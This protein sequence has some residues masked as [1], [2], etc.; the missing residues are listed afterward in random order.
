MSVPELSADLRGARCNNCGTAT[1]HAAPCSRCA[2]QPG[3][4]RP[5]P[6]LPAFFR[7]LGRPFAGMRFLSEHRR[8]WSY[9]LAPLLL[10]TA[11]FVGILMLTVS[12]LGDWIPDMDVAWHPWLDWLRVSVGWLLEVVLYLVG[13]LAASLLTLLLA[14]VVN[15]PFYD[16][17]SERVESAWFGNKDPGRPLRLL[18]IDILRSLRASLSLALRQALVMSLL[19]VL[20]FTAIGAVLFA[21]GGFYYAGL[22]QYD[23]TLARKLYPGSRRARWGRRHALLVLSSGIPLSLVPLLAPF[24]IVGSTL[25][26]LAEPDKQ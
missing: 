11:I 1:E 7:G 6:K 18:A 23:V 19:F 8:L 3:A 10:N 26:F 14:G 2:A 4:E 9:V 20:S 13:L 17:L 12:H 16:V 5:S 24:G 21:I 25:A 15:A 22:A